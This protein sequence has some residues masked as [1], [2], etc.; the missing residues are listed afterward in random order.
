MERHDPVQPDQRRPS[1]HGDQAEDSESKGA[2]SHNKLSSN[3]QQLLLLRHLIEQQQESHRV[4]EAEVR[5]REQQLGGQDAAAVGNQ[6]EN[7]KTKGQ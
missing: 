2:S 7:T 6:S 3:G 4:L 1:H 5:M